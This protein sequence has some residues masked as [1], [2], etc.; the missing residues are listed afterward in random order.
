ML[1]ISIAAAARALQTHQI[2]QYRRLAG[3]P[4][5]FGPQGRHF[6]PL[7]VYL[8]TL[9]RSQWSLVPALF[10]GATQIDKGPCGNPVQIA[11]D[12]ESWLHKLPDS[13]P[14]A[15]LSTVRSI[16]CQT[17]ADHAHSTALLRHSERLRHALPVTSDT[18]LRHVI[19]N[20]PMP[21]NFKKFCLEHAFKTI[22]EQNH[23]KDAA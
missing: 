14:S 17:L 23:Q 2:T 20:E 6:Y 15:R 12:F 7:A 10:N 11:K 13:G 16:Y 1:H 21:S 22:P 4:T 9:R 18:V 3:L 8:P 5:H 19:L